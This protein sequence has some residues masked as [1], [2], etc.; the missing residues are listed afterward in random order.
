MGWLRLYV[1]S[2]RIG[3]A[4][5]TATAGIGLIWTMWMVWGRSPV[6]GARGV[7][8]AVMLAVVAFATTLAGTDDALDRTAAINWP[9]R[10]A[11]HVLLIAVAVVAPLLL[12]TLTEARFEPVEVMLRNTAGLL[13]LTVGGAAVFG[14]AL[15][16]VAPLVWT[17][18]AVMPWIQPGPELGTQIIGW[19]IQPAGTT[20]ATVCALV[21]AVTGLAAYVLRGGPVRPAAE[22]VPD[23]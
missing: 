14:A 3:F 4:L 21:L 2:R 18:I 22:T 6:I 17:L 1:R 23:R 19:L 7:S 15:S 5:A 10:R 12:S 16:W 8:M 11:G 13:G 20:T 9:V